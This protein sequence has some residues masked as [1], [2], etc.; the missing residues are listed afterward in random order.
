MREVSAG[1]VVYRRESDAGLS[2]LMIEDRYSR[3]TLP[4]GKVESGETY[5]ETA[6]REIRE[7]TG[8][9]GRIDRPLKTI[10]Y[11]YFHP[12]HGD[13]AKEVHYFLVEAE[14][15]KAT[16]QLSEISKVAW[17]TPGEAWRRQSSE[18]YDNN[19]DVLLKAFDCLGIK[20]D[21]K[22]GN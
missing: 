1:G 18:G 12:D 20:V 10:T 15:G 21:G 5:E 19:H 4:K 16:P 22:E 2:I 14:E 7:E 8:I 17:L 6:L 13:V 3:W 11:H 9:R